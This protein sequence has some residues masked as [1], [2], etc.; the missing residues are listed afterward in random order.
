MKKFLTL[1]SVSAAVASASIASAGE[2]GKMYFKADA[3]YGMGKDKFSLNSSADLTVGGKYKLPAGTN[4]LS[5]SSN[6]FSKGFIGDVTFGYYISDEVRTDLML[7]YASKS[8]THELALKNTEDKDIKQQFKNSSKNFAVM[9][10][11]YYDFNTGSAFTPFVMAGL[12][13]A[14]GS[15]T[16]DDSDLVKAL[17]GYTETGKSGTTGNITDIKTSNKFGFAYRLGVGVAFEVSRGAYIDLAY[18]MNGRTGANTLAL[19]KPGAAT[20]DP[21]STFKYELKPALTHSVTV[22]F[23]M[24]F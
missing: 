13:A 24:T 14:Y 6:V 17:A 9:A 22:G 10:N 19:E 23:R 3:G 2:A 4:D 11:A 5:P 1:L 16:L 8:A 15:A 20:A 21:K 7:S 12:G 18:A